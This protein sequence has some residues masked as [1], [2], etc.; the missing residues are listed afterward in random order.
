M[1]K[2]DIQITNQFLNQKD[3]SALQDQEYTGILTEKQQS[4]SIKDSYCTLLQNGAQ[5]LEESYGPNL[6]YHLSFLFQYMLYHGFFSMNQEEFKYRD[7]YDI[8]FQGMH[9]MEGHGGRRNITS[10]YQ[11]LFHVLL[12]KYSAQI[13]EINAYLP[14]KEERINRNELEN[15]DVNHVLNFIMSGTQIY[16]YDGTNK[17]F[18]ISDVLSKN[19]EAFFAHFVKDK[20]DIIVFPRLLNPENKEINLAEIIFFMNQQPN[21]KKKELNDIKREVYAD[22]KKRLDLLRDFYSQNEGYINEIGEY[23]RKKK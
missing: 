21:I 23:I 8:I 16:L 15:L 10:F 18:A 7:T 5:F 11:N 9:V 20:G 12:S 17:D 6:I 2:M 1:K 3:S 22:C 4:L 19:S 14:D 13:Y